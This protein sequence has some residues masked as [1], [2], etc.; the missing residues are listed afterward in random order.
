[1]IVMTAAPEI[2]VLVRN[3]DLALHHLV[4]TGSRAYGIDMPGSDSDYIGVFTAPLQQFVSLTG[5]H[6]ETYT[7]FKPD[8]ALHELGKY[9]RL[10]L[11]GNPTILETLWDPDV[12]EQDR[13]GRELVSMRGSFLHQG[14]LRA[15]AAYA[16]GQMKRLTAGK[17]V[18]AK[19]GA[20]NGKYGAHLLRLLHA[21]IGLARTGEV[22]VR[23]TPGLAST[24]L[25]VRS[26][27][28]SMGEVLE[29]ARPLVTKLEGLM[30]SD[31]LPAQPDRERVNEFVTRARLSRA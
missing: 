9:C 17:A 13:W 3:R 22:E 23:V 30:A 14:C 26:G 15:Y 27:Q 4:R 18:H 11:K 5:L 7:G 31:R 8:F 20:Y 16:E 6:E 24:L 1:M 29:M 12:V 2:G 21:G 10:A 28:V 25:S 19:G